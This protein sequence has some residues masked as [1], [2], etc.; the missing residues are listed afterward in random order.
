MDK[1][2]RRPD[3]AGK[4]RA[5]PSKPA[6]PDTA[7]PA[8]RAGQP[9]IIIL[10]ATMIATQKPLEAQEAQN[11]EKDPFEVNEALRF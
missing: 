1:G 4:A 6:S 2:G 3:P 11:E 7:R 5:G 10:V 8:R 9:Q